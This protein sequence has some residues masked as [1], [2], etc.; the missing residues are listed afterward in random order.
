MEQNDFVKHTITSG[1]QDHATTMVD[2][3]TALT[4]VMGKGGGHTPILDSIRRLTPTECERLQGFPDGWTEYGLD[5]GLDLVEI[6][7]TQ[8][9]KCLGNAVTTN[10]VMAIMERIIREGE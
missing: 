4:E 10:V 5:E 8:R 3:S 2:K 1:L 9:Y 7:D 6:S